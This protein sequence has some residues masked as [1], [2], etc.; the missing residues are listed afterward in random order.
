LLLLT[1]FGTKF[2]R[3]CRP[4]GAPDPEIVYHTQQQLQEV[5]QA[6]KRRRAEEAAAHREAEAESPLDPG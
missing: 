5:V 1:D 3:A 2:V 6:N 4:P